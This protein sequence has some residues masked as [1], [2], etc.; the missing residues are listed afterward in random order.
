M[1]IPAVMNTYLRAQVFVRG[2]CQ[3]ALLSESV[4]LESRG[5][6]SQ[7][8]WAGVS[9]HLE[10]CVCLVLNRMLPCHRSHFSL[11]IG[12]VRHCVMCV[13]GVRYRTAHYE[14]RHALMTTT[15]C[16]ADCAARAKECQQDQLCCTVF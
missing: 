10:L 5:L 6:H 16:F 3:I 7:P 4:S 1:Q 15:C 14:E 2:F 12:T 13:E 9:F 8:L 11:I